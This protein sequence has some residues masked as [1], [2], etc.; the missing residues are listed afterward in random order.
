[1]P[2]ALFEL[3]RVV[4]DYGGLRPLRIDALTL[5]ERERLAVEGFDLAAAEVLVN[6]ITGA[7]LPDAGAVTLF[8]RDTA[9]IT[10][11]TDWLAVVDR[12][13]I[14]SARTVLLESFSIAQNLALPF[15][16]EI[17]PL[18]D[19]LRV[20][21]IAL[22]KDVG[23]GPELADRPVSSLGARERLAVRLGRALAFDP[24]V[25][26]LEHPTADLSGA[27][28]MQIGAAVR[29]VLERREAAGLA[30]TADAAFARGFASG[31]LH[32]SGGTGRITQTGGWLS[33]LRSQP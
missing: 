15:S 24:R 9:T 31:L 25:V 4:K 16:L 23:L 14:V 18:S 32:W 26:L 12:F 5:R 27:D 13:G 30:L 17:E 3:S 20:R 2:D 7:T 29:A 19:E 21:A 33:R 1:M 11:S 6:V 28:S 8:G 10:D 22:G